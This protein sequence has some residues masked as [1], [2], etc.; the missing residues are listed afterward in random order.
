GCLSFYST[1][2]MTSGHF[3]DIAS[4][5]GETYPSLRYQAGISA[6]AGANSSVAVSWISER[7]R[8]QPDSN[9]VTA[10]YSLSLGNGLFF[11]LTGLR[12]I[13]AGSSAAE[14]FFSM[15]FGGAIAS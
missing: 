4:L 9:L 11:G 8:G 7:E 14:M 15:P 12:N 5:D 3:A 6:A 13:A 2:A 10:S 1:I